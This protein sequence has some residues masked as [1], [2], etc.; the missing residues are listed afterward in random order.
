MANKMNN[1]DYPKP[2][3]AI[4]I[5][6][7]FL[8]ILFFLLPSNSFFPLFD[9]STKMFD[10]FDTR[11]VLFGKVSV[12]FRNNYPSFFFSLCEGVCYLVCKLVY[13]IEYF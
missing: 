3:P 2:V 11:Y 4:P 1:N 5:L 8:P 13:I 10:F 12:R 9:F 6:S 7:F